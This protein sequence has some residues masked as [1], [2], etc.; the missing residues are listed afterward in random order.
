MKRL[1]FT[2][3]ILML[4]VSACASGS[5]RPVGRGPDYTDPSYPNPSPPQPSYPSPIESPNDVIPKP[6]D[7]GMTRDLV[8][9][10]SVDLL[11]MESFPP[12]FTL[13]LKGTL[14]TPCHQLRVDVRPPDAQNRIMVEVYSLVKPDMICAMVLHAFEVNVPLGSFPPGKYTLWVNGELVTEFEA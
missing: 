4:V 5:D 8:Y 3:L 1:L 12:Q 7:S 10:D 2:L 14:P 13:A 11:T 9:L 6:G